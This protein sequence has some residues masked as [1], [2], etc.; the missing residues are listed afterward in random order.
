M[1]SFPSIV[2]DLT[3]QMEAEATPAPQEHQPAVGEASAAR[4]ETPQTASITGGSP[5]VAMTMENLQA[6]LA[7]AV[8]EGSVRMLREPEA[9]SPKRRM[10]EIGGRGS[11]GPARA[12]SSL[13][14]LSLFSADILD[15]DLPQSFRPV[16]YEYLGTTDPCEHLCRFNNTSDLHR[17][18]E[19]VKCRVFATTLAGAAQ[20]W[21]SQL[22]AGTIGSFDQLSACFMDHFASS[23]KQKRSTLT[24]FAVRH[25]EGE[26]LR[27]FIKRFISSTLE[28]PI[29][30]EEVLISA[31]AQG[32]R[33]GDFFTSLSKKPPASFNALLK[34]AERYMNA[35]EA[36]HN[37]F[38]DNKG[39]LEPGEI[40]LAIENNPKLKWPRTYAEAP[41]KSPTL[42]SFCRFHNDYGHTTNECQHLRDEIERLIRAKNLPEFV[43]EGNQRPQQFPARRTN[44]PRKPE[45][46]REKLNERKDQVAPANFISMILG[47]PSGGDSNRARRAHLRQLRETEELF[48]E[49]EEVDQASRAHLRRLCEMEA[50]LEEVQKISYVPPIIFG[51]QDE[52]GIRQPHSDALVITAMVAN[53]D[54]ARILVDIGSSAD[55]IYYDCFRKMNMDFELKYVETSLVGFS[56][57]SVRS[58]GEVCL[59]ISLGME[60]VRA[61]RSVKFLVLDA[62]STYNIILGRPSMNSFQAVVS[63]YHM[64]LKFPVLDQIGEVHGG[65]ETS[66][67]CYYD[68][69]RRIGNIDAI[70]TVSPGNQGKEDRM[71]EV[72]PAKEEAHVKPMEELMVVQL[73]EKDASRTTRIGGGLDTD[74]S[75]QLVEF[76]RQNQDVFAFTPADLG[77]IDEQLVVHRL[78]VKQNAKP[79]KQKR[80]HFG[81]EKDKIIQEEVRKLLAAGQ[82]REIRF[83][84]WLSNAVLVKKGEGKW[85]MCIDFRDLNKACPKDYYPLPRIDQLVD[86]TAGCEMLSMMDASQGYHQIPL[87]LGDQP[88]V[89]FITSTGTYCYTVMP[90]GL[91][92][93]GATYQRLVEKMSKD[94]LGRNMEIYVDDMLVKSQKA[95][96]HLE[97]L[98]ETFCTLRRYGMKLNPNKCAFGVK[99][100]K[101]LG[102]M[103]TER[104][105]EVNPEKVQAVLDMEAPRNIKEVQMQAGRITA[106]SRFISKAGEASHPFFKILRKGT[107]FE[108]TEES[109]KAFEQ[110]KSLLAR[111]PLLAKPV[112]GEKLYVYLAVG[113]FA[114]SSVFAQ[115]E[116]GVQSPVYYAS[117]LLR[118]AEMR[119]SEIE[120]M[121]LALVTT[122]RK[123]RPYFI[124]H[125]IVVRTNHPMKT[126]MGRMEVSGRM[127]KW[128]VEMGQF[129]ISYE[130]WIA[131]KGQALA[132]FLQETT[133][134]EEQGIW[135]VFVDGS[136]NASG[137]GVGVLLAEAGEE[138]EYAI[139]LPFKAS[140]NEAEYEAVIHGMKLVSSA[141]G[142][143]LNIFSDSQL[144]VQQ[145]KGEFEIKNER[146][147][148]YCEIVRSMMSEFDFCELAQIPREENQH[149]DF[150]AKV[151]SMAVGYE[152]RKIQLLVGEPCSGGEERVATVTS[153]EDWRTEIRACLQGKTL[154]SGRAR[155]VLEQRAS[156]FCL[157]GDILHKRGYTRPH[158]RCLSLEEG[159]YVLREVHQGC[160]GDH[161]GGRAL[162]SRVLRAGYFWPTSRKD[163][164]QFVKRCDKCQR[165]GPLIHTPGEDMTIITS[166]YPFAQWGIDIVGPMPLAK[167]QRK[168][169]IVAV[170]YFSKWVE[171]VAVARITDTEVMKFIWQNICCRYGLPRDLI[172]DNGTQFNSA[173]IRGWCAGL[174]IKQRFAAVAHP[175]ANG[176]VEVIN[177][178]LLEGIKKRLEGAKGNW[179]EELH[180]VLWG[181]RTSLKEATGESPFSLV[182]GSEAVIPV[183]VGMPSSRIMNFHETANSMRLR[184]ELDLV[185]EKQQ[186]AR[187]RMELSKAKIK[188]A[189]DKK[190]D[191]LKTVGKLMEKWEGPY[192]VVAVLVGGAYMLEDMNGLRIARAW[193]VCHLK[194]YYI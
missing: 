76:L 49:I 151:G 86:S 23:K 164:G 58:V 123:L 167:G 33:V 176:Q 103:V 63:T 47:G 136:A 153:G 99:T 160:S 44:E 106:L 112:P 104:G 95:S 68:A 38:G 82:I 163:A 137:S 43:K 110:L 188:A 178:V 42:G 179:V 140:N 90:F 93:A 101:F 85:R 52:E 84:S 100:G 170:D 180:A 10:G 117:K 132:D 122:A 54:I 37:K 8:H 162:V 35:E 50:Q 127:V 129:D 125:A 181:Y 169:L 126:V 73:C 64:K 133:R 194:R 193:N 148:A 109:E 118:G 12:S 96:N 19:G 39:G 192:K 146:M 81:A 111:L 59:P 172:S 18:T 83:P 171:A 69:L 29:T 21:F 5:L 149:A 141:G 161:A 107:Q 89:S 20:A 72:D 11:E 165:H 189:Y 157:I 45:P 138:L 31:L 24:L 128:A 116:E 74:M 3:S 92:N 30:S 175:Q 17:F 57:E 152:S 13:S 28:V 154:A 143:K 105:V 9:A 144:V 66:R 79:V 142:R 40:L 88:K 147:M 185:M 4:G 113:E 135:R 134:P 78:N 22:P 48:G 34:K 14:A 80:R 56:G 36:V 7:S 168:F 121:G 98:K 102:H 182:Y 70:R 191:A 6:L 26:Y 150:L 97:D 158:L 41:R 55:V 94:Q 25:R 91:K 156:N 190:A 51:P 177:R 16:T 115:E 62:P 139:K 15:D 187:G 27:S 124:S 46:G 120:K 1:A 32:L 2:R 60:P 173:K 184:E 155:K 61:T 159:S 174:G 145:V 119:Y 130:P 131:I 186:S 67:R 53:F 108:W 166:P 65:Q 77:S 183:E 75:R 87:C 71:P 114:V